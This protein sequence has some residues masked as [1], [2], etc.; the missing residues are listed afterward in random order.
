MRSIS[1]LDVPDPQLNEMSGEALI[2]CASRDVYRIENPDARPHG[3][4]A[5]VSVMSPRLMAGL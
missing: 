4:M 5:M 2:R 1:F 3:P